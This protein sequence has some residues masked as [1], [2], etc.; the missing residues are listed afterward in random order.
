MNQ[1]TEAQHTPQ[2]L[3]A[4]VT[5]DLIVETNERLSKLAYSEG[6]TKKQLKAI[7]KAWSAL[8]E[9][10]NVDTQDDDDPFIWPEHIDR[11]GEPP[12]QL[13]PVVGV[14]CVPDQP[15]QR[16]THTHNLPNPQTKNN[17]PLAGY[18]K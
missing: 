7:N 16:D 17:I 11:K 14:S 5:Y 2:G 8:S 6:L 10:V 18:K 4:K 9:I 13:R 12:R 15:R 1:T 3:I